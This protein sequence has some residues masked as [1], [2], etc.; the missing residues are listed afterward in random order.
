MVMDNWLNKIDKDQKLTKLSDLLLTR[1]D[2]L[3]R[4]FRSSVLQPVFVMGNY[5]SNTGL[6]ELGCCK[7]GVTNFVTDV[8]LHTLTCPLKRRYKVKF[9][10]SEEGG[11]ATR[12]Y[13]LT[14]MI[15]GSGISF[16]GVGGVMA[17]GVSQ[18][19]VGTPLCINNAGTFNPG[20]PGPITL[21][22]GDTLSVTMSGWVGGDGH[23]TAFIY[24]EEVIG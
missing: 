19:L 10:S 23:N 8:A 17:A 12:A 5:N 14:G 13:S 21:N 9:V 11:F 4:W 16:L 2:D 3:R 7:Q 20:I 24:D 15:E 1:V 18:I 22:P 6:I